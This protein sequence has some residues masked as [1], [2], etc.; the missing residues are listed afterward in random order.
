MRISGFMLGITNP[1]LIKRLH[2]NIP[3]SVDEMWRATTEFLRGEDTASNQARRK[4]PPTWKLQEGG[5]KYG[6]DSGKA[7][8]KG[9]AV[10]KDKPP[11]ILMVQPWQRVARQRIPQ[12]FSSNPEISFPS[13]G[14]E[15]GT[16]GSIVIETKM[17]KPS[18]TAKSKED[19]S[20]RIDSSRNVKISGPGTR[21]PLMNQTSAIEEKI[22]IAI[23]P[24]QTIEIGSTLLEEW[25]E[26]LYKLLRK[27]LDVFAWKPA[28]MIGVPRH[29]AEL[30]LNVWEGCLPV[31]QKKRGQA[32]ERN[33]AIQEEVENW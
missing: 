9:E 23:Y 16:K 6:K 24:K 8:K 7:A 28:D 2:D 33:K 10:E 32:P 13:L 12:S 21:Q 20:G 22:K 1:E 29:I 15:D 18:Y 5:R 26:E 4:G 11:A 27:S 31:R 14:E 25:R 19:P 17:G 30:R 3:K